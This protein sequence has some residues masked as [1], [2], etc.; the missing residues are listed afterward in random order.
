MNFLWQDR[1]RLLRHKPFLFYLLHMFI[2]VT[3]GGLAYV[4]I[5]WHCFQASGSIHTVAMLSIMF[6]GPSVLLGPFAGWATDKYPRKIILIVAH[7]F[8]V[9]AFIGIGWVLTSHHA[10][11]W[12]YLV[13]MTNGIVFAIAIPAFGAFTRELVEDKDLLLANTTVDAAFE[14]ANIL[15]MGLTGLL[16]LTLS[17]ATGLIIVGCFI[18]VG[19]AFLLFIR[20]KDLIPYEKEPCSNFIND[21]KIAIHCSACH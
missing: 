15:G 5:I 21:W 20:Q 14:T 1:L 13:S 4:L 16:M 2:T 11:Y 8:R 19:A 10:L 7:T 12:S 17:Y 18:A 9:I 6:W 3:G